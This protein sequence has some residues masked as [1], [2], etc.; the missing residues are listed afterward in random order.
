MVVLGLEILIQWSLGQMNL[1]LFFLQNASYVWLWEKRNSWD[2]GLLR[3]EEKYDCKSML[4][5]SWFV[6]FSLILKTEVTSNFFYQCKSRGRNLKLCFLLLSLPL[7]WIFFWY[8]VFICHCLLFLALIV[9]SCTSKMPLL[10]NT[11]SNW[12]WKKKSGG[13]A[14][15]SA[16]LPRSADLWSAPFLP[17]LLFLMQ[18]CD[19]LQSLSL[20]KSSSSVVVI[21]CESSETPGRSG[22]SVDRSVGCSVWK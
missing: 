10:V 12:D 1:H 20:I 17:F 11:A 5:C 13:F 3:E 7:F 18:H 21:S 15:W 6:F 22:K 19:F 14:K 8:F 4:I 9:A 2:F 16:T